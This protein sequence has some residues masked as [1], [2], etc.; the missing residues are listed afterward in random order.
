MARYRQRPEIVEAIQFTGG[1][2]N[3]QAVVEWLKAR[4][5]QATWVDN[6]T[7][8]DLH[9]IQRIQFITSIRPEVVNSAYPKDWITMKGESFRIYPEKAFIERFEKV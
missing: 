4:A 9:L 1:A 3:A 7:V 6:Q 5:C 2:E 8:M